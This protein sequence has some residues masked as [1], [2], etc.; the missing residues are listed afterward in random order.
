MFI[1]EDQIILRKYQS[2]RACALTGY[3]RQQYFVSEWEDYCK[4]KRD[5]TVNKEVTAISFKI[6]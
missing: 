5:G 1:E 3:F 4:S 6:K 2:P